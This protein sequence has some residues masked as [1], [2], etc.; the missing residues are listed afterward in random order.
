MKR[1]LMT[2]IEKILGIINVHDRAGIYSITA[3]MI[4][5]YVYDR[6]IAISAL[7]IDSILKELVAQDRIVYDATNSYFRPVS[8]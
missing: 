3:D 2:K 5:D 4:K 7:E 8:Y 6:K 1:K